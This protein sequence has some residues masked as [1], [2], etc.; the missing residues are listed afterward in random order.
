M[1]KSGVVFSI[2]LVV[3]LI[4]AVMMAFKLGLGKIQGI[5]A[6]LDSQTGIV[7]G[8][9]AAVVLLCSM[10]LAAAIR[11]AGRRESEHRRQSERARVYEALLET[12]ADRTANSRG[13]ASSPARTLFLIGSVAV[14]KE[15]RALLTVLSA[16]DT[17][18]AHVRTHVNRLLLAMRRDIGESTFGLE[19]EDWSDWLIAATNRISRKQEPHP[20]PTGT[21][22]LPV[23]APTLR[24]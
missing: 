14:V 16:K 2:A 20:S 7:L 10:S 6:G 1:K 8:V 23:G 21:S 12:L 9:S 19:Q 22:A 15:Y 18:E 13:E 17:D 3:V 4:G 5:F 24:L 11:S